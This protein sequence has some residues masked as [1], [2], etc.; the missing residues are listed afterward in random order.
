MCFC[1][2]AQG[3]DWMLDSPQ[4]TL[5]SVQAGDGGL[6]RCTATDPAER[7]LRSSQIISIDVLP[8][9]YHC[10]GTCHRRQG[11]SCMWYKCPLHYKGRTHIS[12]GIVFSLQTHSLR[13]TCSQVHVVKET[14]VGLPSHGF[15]QVECRHVV[16]NPQWQLIT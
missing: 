10:M 4:L 12:K 16:S 2:A 15:P 11:K 8:G 9:T 14:G 7:S 1:V 5:R 6:Y 3:E 13:A